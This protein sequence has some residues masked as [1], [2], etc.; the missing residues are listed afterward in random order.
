MRQ[1]RDVDRHKDDRDRPDDIAPALTE[2]G[3]PRQSIRKSQRVSRM[4]GLVSRSPRHGTLPLRDECLDP[5]I[6]TRW[7]GS[8]VGRLSCVAR[9]ADRRRHFALGWTAGAQ[10]RWIHLTAATLLHA[11]I[12]RPIP[13]R[14]TGTGLTGPLQLCT[15]TQ[16]LTT[17]A[18]RYRTA[19][20]AT[21]ASG[22]LYPE[23]ENLTEPIPPCPVR[24][25]DPI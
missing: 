9:V 25:P 20:M 10:L 3:M 14:N 2:R 7:A 17:P 15:G 12:H 4:S 19:C 24:L 11:S 22:C 1:L 5:D 8:L 13:V 16:V 6:Q 21:R 18:H 23:D